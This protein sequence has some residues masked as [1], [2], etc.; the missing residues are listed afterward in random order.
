MKIITCRLSIIF[1]LVLLTIAASGQIIFQKTFSKPQIGGFWSTST[2]SNSVQTFDGGYAVMATTGFVAPDGP[3]VFL[4][5]T[6]E[7]GAVQWTLDV[8]DTLLNE[9]MRFQQTSDSG[10]IISG[11]TAKPDNNGF[12]QLHLLK[13]N[14]VGE[15]VW[16]KYYTKGGCAES[17]GHYVQQTRDGGFIVTGEAGVADSTCTWSRWI[18]LLKTDPDGT[19]EWSKIFSAAGDDMGSCVQ[20]TVDGG[21]IVGG[22]IGDSYTDNDIALI[23]TDSAGNLEWS[24]RIGGASCDEA[25]SVKQTKNQGYVVTGYTKSFDPINFK[26]FILK[27]D[28]TGNVQS[29]KTFESYPEESGADI[30]LTNDGGYLIAGTRADTLAHGFIIKLDSLENLQWSKSFTG[31]LY[32]GFSS[33]H[34]TNDGGFILS[35]L[36][37]ESQG[38]Y[39]K[40]NL[41]KTDGE[42]N[43]VCDMID[44]ST[45]LLDEAITESSGITGLDGNFME[46]ESP[47]SSQEILVN[48][49][50][51]CV[52]TNVA[53][54]NDS[55]QSL[56]IFP[57]PASDFIS[58]K[59][60]SKPQKILL[61]DVVGRI[62]SERNPDVSEG[63]I[64][65]DISHLPD[66]LYVLKFQC[67]EIYS[68]QTF[69]KD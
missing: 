28:L 55:N 18:F 59:F 38:G 22:T 8:G 68:A 20:Q 42:G 45:K 58:V 19:L 67:D 51:V 11:C 1:F 62:V 34:S 23:K 39:A 33:V 15:L 29:F 53:N 56:Q 27:I 6:D 17:P 5:K 52:S 16:S 31:L 12:Y 69:I 46:Y 37:V 7:Y 2:T 61:M 4:L 10:F 24:K 44:D 21:F 35:G 32:N 30:E 48:Q 54:M 64:T 40:I 60:E 47:V 43:T 50:T 3:N 36:G 57:N 65:F 49:S 41:L 25:Y 14:A 66:G 9:A 13:V 63:T 26:G